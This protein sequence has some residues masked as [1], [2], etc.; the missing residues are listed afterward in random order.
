MSVKIA[1]SDFDDPKSHPMQNM[2][3]FD[4]VRI[5]RL[6]KSPEKYDDWG[7]NTQPVAVG[8]TG[9][10]VDVLQVEGVDDGYVVENVAT[11][12]TTVWL[13]IFHKEEIE[14]V[15]SDLCSISPE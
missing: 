5:V 12:G 1:A 3:P 13:S 11:D 15:D 7:F 6:I 9:A 10:L 14:P 8:D 4:I 2:K